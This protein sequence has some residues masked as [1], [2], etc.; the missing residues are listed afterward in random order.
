MCEGGI[1]IPQMRFSVEQANETLAL[2]QKWLEQLNHL[3]DH[4]H[5]AETST[6]LAQVTIMLSEARKK[7]ETAIDGLGGADASG[8]TVEVV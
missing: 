2:T 7:L 8:V 6:E 4:A 3:A 1:N 5:H